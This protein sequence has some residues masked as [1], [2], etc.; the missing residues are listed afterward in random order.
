MQNVQNKALHSG[1]THS[2]GLFTNS[3]LASTGELTLANTAVEVGVELV[4]RRK[5]KS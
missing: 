3:V 4:D 1:S 2:R 5:N